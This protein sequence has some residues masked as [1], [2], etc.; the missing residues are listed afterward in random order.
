[1]I[2]GYARVS[3]TDQNP[4]LQL[5]A[6]KAAG[7]ERVFVDKAS[8]ASAKRPELNKLMGTVKAGDQVTVWKLDR[9]ARSLSDM[10]RLANDL[11]ER[12]VDL[13]SLN[14]PVD[15]TSAMG[16]FIFQLTG[17]FAELERSMIQERTNAGLASARARGVRVGRPPSLSAAQIAHAKTLL[18][19]GE[20]PAQ[21]ARTFGVSRSTLY[22]AF[23]RYHASV[24]ET[25]KK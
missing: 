22:R 4:D 11:G 25:P 15:T 21:V 14:D 19:T 16:R 6:L 2:Y 23:E 1:M 5:D 17:A 24:L 12:E 9:F 13:V 20:S 18:D 10:L 3:T 8:G 7:C